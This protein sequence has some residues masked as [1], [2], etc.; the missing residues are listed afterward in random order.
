[1]E[2]DAHLYFQCGHVPLRIMESP[3]SHD[4]KGLLDIFPLTGSSD[5]SSDSCL[6]SLSWPEQQYSWES[7]PAPGEFGV[8]SWPFRRCREHPDQFWG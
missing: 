8:L 1:M 2:A 7:L 3:L 5:T 6:E 4:V